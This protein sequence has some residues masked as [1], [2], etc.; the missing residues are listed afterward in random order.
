VARRLAALEAEVDAV[1]TA[2]A[3]AT[4]ELT[5]VRTDRAA[6]ELQRTRM[7][8]DYE[9]IDGLYRDIAA[10]TPSLEVIEVLAPLGVRILSPAYVPARAEASRALL[11]SLLAAVVTA[12][13]MIVLL[14]LREAVSAQPGGAG[15]A[16]PTRPRVEAPS[17]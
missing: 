1:A 9:L 6:L 16:V 8:R 10:L 11:V 13:G 15:P 12:F 7:Q 14:L 17:G 3:T 5:Q 2:L 4:R